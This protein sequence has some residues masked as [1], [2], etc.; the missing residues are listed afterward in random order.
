MSISLEMASS[1]IKLT[2]GGGATQIGAFIGLASV[3]SIGLNTVLTLNHST[4]SAAC[5]AHTK[6]GDVCQLRDV[7]ALGHAARAAE[8]TD[9]WVPAD[10]VAYMKKQ[11]GD[12]ITNGFD[13]F[14]NL[15]DVKVFAAAAAAAPAKKH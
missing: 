6:D 7:F 9:S 1:F 8:V 4:R 2:L 15:Y 5:V 14:D 13:V 12:P 3:V 11:G 10:D